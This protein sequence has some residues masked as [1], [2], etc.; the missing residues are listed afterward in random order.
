MPTMR[1]YILAE[2]FLHEQNTD[3][4]SDITTSFLVSHYIQRIDTKRI[5]NYLLLFT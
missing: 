5:I 2:H 1:P 4:P 3:L